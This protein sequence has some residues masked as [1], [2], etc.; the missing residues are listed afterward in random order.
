MKKKIID[1]Q[2]SPIKKIACQ[3]E[4][5]PEEGTQTTMRY[6]KISPEEKKE[7]EENENAKR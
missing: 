3:T 5:S 4:T 6:K 2:R 1:N 7:Y